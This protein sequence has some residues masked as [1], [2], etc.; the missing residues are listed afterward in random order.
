MVPGSGPIPGYRG[1]MRSLV[2][3]V[4]SCAALGCP[5]APVLAP[6]VSPRCDPVSG[7]GRFVEDG[8]ARGVDLEVPGDPS[9]GS[10]AYVPG[11]VVAEDLDDDGDVDLLFADPF[12]SP[13]AYR[14]DGTGRF[15]RVDLGLTL[16]FADRY[17]LGLSVVD[18]DGDG[19]PELAISGASYAAV[20][21]NLG[22]FLF[23]PYAV[24][25]D[26]PGFPQ[27][28]MNAMAW[29]DAD[30]DGD[31][32]LLLPVLDP[33]PFAGAPP[34]DDEAV[35]GA[36]AR[37]LLQEA[38]V[39]TPPMPLSPEGVDSVAILGVFTDQDGDGT[40]EILL[41][42]DRGGGPGAGVT[43]FFR[44]TAVEPLAFVDE[45]NALAVDQPM[46]VMGI[47]SQDVNG[48][49]TLDYCLSDARPSTLRCWVSTPQGYV[50]SALA[51]GL[52]TTPVNTGDVDDFWVW[53]TWSLEWTDLD[54][55][56][57]ADVVVV[58]GPPPPDT[59]GESAFCA[60]QP[61]AIYQGAADGRWVDRSMEL[62]WD[63]PEFHYGL[64]AA[65]LEGDG[66]PEL[67]VGPWRGR[68]QIWNNP[69]GDHRWLDVAL[70]GLPLN[71]RGLGARV[72]VTT[73]R[74]VHVQEIHGPRVMGQSPA[75][76]HVGLGQDDI[77]RRIDVVW[78]DGASSTVVP[79]GSSLVVVSHP[80]VGSA[81]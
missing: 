55:D 76:V 15:D 38:G 35:V 50:E 62:G 30:G 51:L 24:V 67:I 70:A 73:D 77:A 13:A 33:V 56:G 14:N 64:A 65:D 75:I 17:A 10:C 9:P 11:G 63:S 7:F 74:A 57:W 18:L 60:T 29:G 37:L 80:Q 42:A 26:S 58:G 45:A 41:G 20:A 4:V 5:S 79:D 61:D 54:N 53:S 1:D 34:V 66:Y 44:R 68:P 22:G 27:R 81:R 71:R 69:C 43:A 59:C 31:L 21:S 36:P 23:G 52:S 3:V 72:T 6:T 19:L 12:G 28:C 2:L 8:L 46:S 48:D 49:G 40:Q 39:F 25:H 47:D 32:D 16:P 78:P